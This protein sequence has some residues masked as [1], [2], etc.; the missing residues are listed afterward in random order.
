MGEFNSRHLDLITYSPNFDAKTIL[1]LST[2]DINK[3]LRKIYSFLL[4]KII[5]NKKQNKKKQKKT[6]K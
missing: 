2:D 5:K 3:N 1:D 4:S 6:T